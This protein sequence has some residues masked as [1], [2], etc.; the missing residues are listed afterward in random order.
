MDYLNG[1]DV[2]R[3]QGDIDFNAVRDAGMQFVFIKATEGGTFVDPRFTENWQK[4]NAAG[5]KVGVYHYFRAT[6]STPEEQKNNIVNT[7]RAAGFDP[8][9]HVLAIDIE[10]ARNTDATNEQMADNAFELLQKL[11]QD[12]VLGGTLPLIYCDN[13]TWRNHLDAQRHDFSR[14]GLWIANWNVETPTIPDTWQ[15]AGKDWSVWQYS[16]KGRVAGI[17][18]D[19]DLDHS[20]LWMP[21]C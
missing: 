8:A 20:R 15:Q 9:V 19:V 14:Y 4:A 16:S 21:S 3:W 2:S 1:I 10:T 11:E 7:L 17:D 13:N 18:G 12:G 6:S 5:L